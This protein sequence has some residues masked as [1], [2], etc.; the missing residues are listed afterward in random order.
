[1]A[2]TELSI[3]PSTATVSVTAFDVSTDPRAVCVPTGAFFQPVLPGHETLHFPLFAFLVEHKA[4]DWR[5]MFDL[6]ARKDSDMSKFPAST[7]LVFGGA[8]ATETHVSEPS[9]GRKLVPLNLTESP[10]EIGGFKA[11]DFFGDGS[12][13]VLDVPGRPTEPDSSPARHGPCL[14]PGAGHPQYFRLHGRRLPAITLEC[15]APRPPCISTPHA[16]TTSSQRPATPS[17]AA[18]F[19]PLDA[20]GHFA[21]AERHTP[22]LAPSTAGGYADV[23]T[24]TASIAT[25]GG[26][27]ASADVLVVLAHDHSLVPAIGPFPVSLDAWKAKGFK[28]QVTW[29]FIEKTNPAFVFSPKPAA[30]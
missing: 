1:M 16:P 23:P 7:S 22:L 25:I 6:G 30:S 19:T 13:Y 4:Q 28:D 17:H 15:S 3:P 9:D 29:A 20:E 11:H 8:T 2:S 26:F 18:H 14:R 12:F 5:V 27:N 24:T 21:L 10:L